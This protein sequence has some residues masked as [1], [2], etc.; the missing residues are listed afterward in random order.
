MATRR[1]RLFVFLFGLL[2]AGVGIFLFGWLLLALID[3]HHMKSWKPVEA[4]LLQMELV[5]RSGPDGTTYHVD[6][7]YRYEYAGNTWE[8]DRVAIK[9]GAG[10]GMYWPNL[11][12]RIREQ[13]ASG[14]LQVYVNPANPQESVLDRE[15]D[16]GLVAPIALTALLFGGAGLAM[17]VASVRAPRDESLPASATQG[18]GDAA[19]EPWRDN[20]DGPLE[21]RVVNTKT[22]A[23][24]IWF[25]A[26]MFLC[27]AFGRGAFLFSAE[28]IDKGN[29]GVIL[30]TLALAAIG[31]GLLVMAIRMTWSAR[32][33][34]DVPLTL[35]PNPGAIG[36]DVGGWID[37]PVAYDPSLAFHITLSCVRVRGSGEDRSRDAKWHDE[38]WLLAEPL[39][40]GRVRLWFRFEPPAG[41]PAAERESNDYHRWSLRVDAKLPGLDFSREYELPVFA[42]GKRSLRNVPAHVI[43]ATARESANIEAKTHVTRIPG[44][45]A[46][47]FSAG[48]QSP[49]GLLLLV[50]GGM[51]GGLGIA[52]LFTDD[53][54]GPWFIGLICALIGAWYPGTG[55]WMIGNSLRVEADDTGLRIRRHCFGILVLAREIARA[56]IAGIGIKKAGASTTGMGVMVY[57]DLVARTLGGELRIIGDGLLGITQARLAGEKF[58]RYARLPFLG[59]VDRPATLTAR[60][61]AFLD[62]RK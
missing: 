62:R 19:A 37:I 5:E 32:K 30:L 4:E 1:G 49:T 25:F 24:G 39:D 13:S 48:R 14:P 10:S 27:S 53:W 36:G 57:Y 52:M 33:F 47:Y 60:M 15:L 3:W 51:F 2:P 11:A 29:W 23:S 43:A 12:A 56:D 50:L 8:N 26:F 7:R 35:D 54:A 22:G 61:A 38:Q 28:E 20:A 17:I 34:G 58:A 6:A 55:L 42:T 21:P 9:E 16:I 41:L 40:T 18:A 46:M 45:A 59:E 31:V 44:G